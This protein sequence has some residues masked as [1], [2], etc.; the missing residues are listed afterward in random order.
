MRFALVVVALL[1]V[2]VMA[3]G[4]SIKLTVDGKSEVT[5]A[6]PGQVLLAEVFIEGSP[7][8]VAAWTAFLRPDKAGL[9]NVVSRAG[10]PAAYVDEGGTLGWNTTGQAP[11]NA[12]SPWVK[13]GALAPDDMRDI[14]LLYD[15]DLG[16]SEY[17]AEPVGKWGIKI[18]DS[19]DGSTINLVLADPLMSDGLGNAI[20]GVVGSTLVITPEPASLLLLGLGGLFLRRRRA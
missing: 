2:P 19:W 17:L 12:N 9:L 6:T 7:D 1:A 4:A 16:Q 20:T 11:P 18:A 8:A 15:W 3:F 14:G 5:D 13:G 10:G